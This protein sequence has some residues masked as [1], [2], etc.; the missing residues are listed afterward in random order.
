M[1]V[2]KFFL[3][4]LF[5]KHPHLVKIVEEQQQDLQRQIARLVKHREQLSEERVLDSDR[6]EYLMKLEKPLRA[7][8]RVRTLILNE[9]YEKNG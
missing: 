1:R 4:R 7:Q 2:V 3:F 6:Y 9:W 5:K 8:L